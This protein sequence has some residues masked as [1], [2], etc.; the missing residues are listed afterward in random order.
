MGK[1]KPLP[2][3]RPI[4]YATPVIA[5]EKRRV[6][7]RRLVFGSGD[8][9]LAM[10]VLARLLVLDKDIDWSIEAPRFHLENINK[11]VFLEG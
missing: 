5:V 11:T 4:S 1:N 3:K 2:G 8:A 9:T 7:G 10:Q 6:C